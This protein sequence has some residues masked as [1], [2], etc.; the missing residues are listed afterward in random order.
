[1]IISKKLS[2]KN[3]REKNM[4]HHC[5]NCS[6]SGFTGGLFIGAVIGGLVA[7][8]YAPQSGEKTREVLKKK[9]SEN[10]EIIDNVK[11]TAEELVNKAKQSF[12]ESLKNLTDSI[13]S[14]MNEVAEA[15]LDPENKEKSSNEQS[16]A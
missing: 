8:L 3:Q 7:L 6:G 2:L 10:Q 16:K 14:K 13:D 12:E 15:A 9:K 11:E 5:S 4:S 1:V